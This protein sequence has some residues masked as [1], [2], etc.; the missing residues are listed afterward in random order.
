MLQR[1]DWECGRIFRILKYMMRSRSARDAGI[2]GPGFDLAEC[3]GAG[4]RNTK[5]ARP[6]S[7][8]ELER[9]RTEM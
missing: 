1:E 7:G 4:P 6:H 5:F 2:V 3:G 9:Y 8:L